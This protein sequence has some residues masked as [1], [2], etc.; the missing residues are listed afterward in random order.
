[1]TSTVLQLQDSFPKTL[2]RQN[3]SVLEV[4]VAHRNRS[5]VVT[6]DRQLFVLQN[7]LLLHGCRRWQLG[8]IAT[9][10]NV[11]FLLSKDILNYWSYEK[12]FS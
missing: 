7:D 8:L 5:Q 6:L 9:H 12:I 1:M 4:I 11:C 3:V 10:L 2:L